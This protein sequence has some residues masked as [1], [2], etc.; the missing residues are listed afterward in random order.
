M[1]LFPE[2]LPDFLAERIR[3][4]ISHHNICRHFLFEEIK[5]L[6]EFDVN[7]SDQTDTVFLN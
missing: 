4:N 2:M 1:V 3:I 5:L 7:R 6:N